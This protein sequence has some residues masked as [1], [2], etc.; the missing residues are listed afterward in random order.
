MGGML[1]SVGVGG[2]NELATTT[3][4]VGVGSVMGGG[5]S[6]LGGSGKEVDTGDGDAS[7]A[8]NVGLDCDDNRLD[9]VTDGIGSAV[10]WEG[11]VTV[12]CD[13]CELDTA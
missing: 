9:I 11:G 10:R 4:G 1:E 5:V 13:G 3:D 7:V 2:G 12:I 6:G 8:S